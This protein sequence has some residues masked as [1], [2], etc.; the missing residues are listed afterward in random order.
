MIPIRYKGISKIKSI[1]I[2]DR[3]LKEI[4][5]FDI[6]ENLYHCYQEVKHKELV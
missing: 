6:R 1:D 4:G 2:G 3:V 5:L